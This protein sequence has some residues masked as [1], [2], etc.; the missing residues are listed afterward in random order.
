MEQHHQQENLISVDLLL[1]YLNYISL[2]LT[3]YTRTKPELHNSSLHTWHDKQAAASPWFGF[4]PA[5]NQLLVC[6]PWDQLKG[7]VSA[8]PARNLAHNKQPGT[9]V[10]NLTSFT[11]L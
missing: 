2:H 4:F 5:G 3:I 6:Q 8:T 1:T 10:L 9:P 11:S 7:P